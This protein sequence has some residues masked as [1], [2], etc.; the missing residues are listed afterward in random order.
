MLP[1][2]FG[3]KQQQQHQNMLKEQSVCPENKIQ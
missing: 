1:T 3:K 2:E